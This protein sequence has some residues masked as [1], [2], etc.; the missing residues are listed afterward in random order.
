MGCLEMI[1]VEDIFCDALRRADEL[2]ETVRETN[3]KIKKLRSEV[4]SKIFRMVYDCSDP[5]ELGKLCDSFGLDNKGY[6]WG[7]VEAYENT[8]SR[9]VNYEMCE[10]HDILSSVF[11]ELNLHVRNKAKMGCEKCQ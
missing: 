9:D 8:Y 10:W 7:W 6:R 5:D 1:L 11:V 3:D 2:E 4:D